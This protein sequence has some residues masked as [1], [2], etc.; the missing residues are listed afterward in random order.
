MK[1]CARCRN[2]LLAGQFSRFSASSDGLQSYC[3]DCM[4]EVVAAHRAGGRPTTARIVISSRVRLIL[5]RRVPEGDRMTFWRALLAD[6]CAYCGERAEVRD[7]IV[8]RQKVGGRGAGSH[9]SAAECEN[10]TAAC[11]PCNVAK[12]T[13]SLLGFLA[14][15]GGYAE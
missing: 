9:Q 10:V 13:D 5:R 11:T 6:P 3:K 1:R 2:T 8:P 15:A 14:R 4:S 12:G 7:H